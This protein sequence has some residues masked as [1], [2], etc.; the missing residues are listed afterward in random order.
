MRAVRLRRYDERPTVEQ[1]PEPK[2]TG[3]MTWS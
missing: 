3:H 2:V 1:V